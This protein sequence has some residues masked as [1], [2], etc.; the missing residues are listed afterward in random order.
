[1]C[2]P[3]FCIDNPCLR[4]SLLCTC[5]LAK[6]SNRST[7]PLWR[8]VALSKGVRPSCHSM[9]HKQRQTTPLLLAL[10]KP[11]YNRLPN[12][13]LSFLSYQPPWWTPLMP[14]HLQHAR[15]HLLPL[16]PPHPN[17]LSLNT[18]VAS[19]HCHSLLNTSS[20]MLPN[21]T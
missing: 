21:Q 2:S 14:P 15:K 7:F 12:T 1:M 18:I 5:L 3:M 6:H 17:T 9:I 20:R 10:T 8:S 16:C 19:T 4:N 11:K 13:L